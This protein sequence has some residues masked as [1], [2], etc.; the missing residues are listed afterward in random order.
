MHHA[1][2]ERQ[3]LIERRAA[4]VLDRD[5]GEGEPWTGALGKQ[6]TDA[7]TAQRWRRFG[8]VVAAYRDRYQITDDHPLGT[9]AG[10]DAQ[11]IDAARADAALHRAKQLS[12]RTLDTEQ[13][14]LTMEARQGRTL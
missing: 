6:P 10:S 5:L 14:D 12:Q 3:E 7:R 11:K 9:G 8:Q 1:L 4:A 13:P 2:T